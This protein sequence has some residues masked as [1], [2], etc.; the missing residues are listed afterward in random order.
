[1]QRPQ[2][3]R[4]Q[5][6]HVRLASLLMT[7]WHV[8]QIWTTALSSMVRPSVVVKRA[9]SFVTSRDPVEVTLIVSTTVATRLPFTVRRVVLRVSTDSLVAV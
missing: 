6:E 2:I 4:W 8:S 7:P 1:M 9:S 5:T 3:T